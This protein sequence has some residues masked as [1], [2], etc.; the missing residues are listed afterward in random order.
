MN[1]D[2]LSLADKLYA[3]VQL[4][5]PLLRNIT[6]RVEA[7]LAGTG[8]SIGQRAILELLLAT[9]QATAPE[10]TATLELKR[11]F[12][13]RELHALSE[14]GMIVSVDNPRHRRSVYY[15]L[16]EESRARISEV[17]RREMVQFAAF[18]NRFSAEEIDAFL[19]IQ[20]ALNQAFSRAP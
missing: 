19:R 20:A 12:V 1:E 14:K 10:I 5:R 8:I 13:A 4:T 3:G 7:D 9:D 17:R 15:R 18:A 16:T 2:D 6:A 11:Q